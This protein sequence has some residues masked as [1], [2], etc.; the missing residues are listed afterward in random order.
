MESSNHHDKTKTT[1]ITVSA[2]YRVHPEDRRVF[3]DA[4]VPDMIAANK[5]EGCIYY[6]FSQDLTDENTFHL[7]EGWRDEEAYERHETSE[8]FLTAL[9]TVVKNVRIL[10]REGVRYEVKKMH[11]DDPRGKV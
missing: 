7:L 3:I 8:I 2:Y 4:V 1:A 9:S 11:I 6:A 5:L 10:D